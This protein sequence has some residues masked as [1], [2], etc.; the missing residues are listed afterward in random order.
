MN[1]IEKAINILNNTEADMDYTKEEIIDTS[2]LAI[3]ALEKQIP[4]EPSNIYKVYG[5][6]ELYGECPNCKHTGLKQGI[7]NHCWWCGQAIDWSENET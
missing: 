6:W 5:E 2:L 4:K 1:K 3:S 7:H